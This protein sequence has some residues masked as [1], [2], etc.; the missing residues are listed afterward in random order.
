MSGKLKVKGNIML[1][2]KLD[3]VLKVSPRPEELLPCL[4]L[5]HSSLLSSSQAAFR[6]PAD[7]FPFT[8]RPVQALEYPNP[9]SLLQRYTST[10]A[11]SLVSFLRKV[12]R[13]PLPSPF[14]GPR[15]K[16]R[17]SATASLP[18]T[19]SPTPPRRPAT[20]ALSA[21]SSPSPTSTS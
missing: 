5:A 10:F 18:L 4:E 6:A 2:T 11:A 3:T 21:L 1:A 16:P 15:P 13:Y 20:P 7:P 19:D 12:L 14:V 8:E 17:T 9:D